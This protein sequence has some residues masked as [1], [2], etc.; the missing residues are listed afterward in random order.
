[1]LRE[2]NSS[3]FPIFFLMRAVRG[4]GKFCAAECKSGIVAMCITGVLE[5]VV[6]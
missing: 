4:L 5:N 2:K 6:E 3:V 1:M